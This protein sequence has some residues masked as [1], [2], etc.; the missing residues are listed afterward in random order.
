MYVF[1]LALFLV[2]PTFASESPTRKGVNPQFAGKVVVERT[3][4]GERTLGF[5]RKGRVDWI[6]EPN[7]K[8]FYYSYDTQDRCV[9]VR[10]R[11]HM[12]SLSYKPDGEAVVYKS[13][14]GSTMFAYDANSNRIATYHGNGLVTHYQYNDLNRVFYMETIDSGNNIIQSFEYGLDARGN[15][16]QVVEHDGRI[17][18]YQFDAFSR[19]AEEEVTLGNLQL[20]RWTYTYDAAHNRLSMTHNGV[21]T[22]YEYDEN[23]RMLRAGTVDFAYDD[24]GQTVFMNRDGARTHFFYDG[25][26]MPIRV[27]HPDGSDSHYEYD[28]FGILVASTSNIGG[29]RRFLVDSNRRFPEVIQE[30]AA[31]E[32]QLLAFYVHGRD[33]DPPLTMSRDGLTYTYLTDAHGNITAVTD[34]SGRVV[35]EYRY[36]AFGNPLR[37]TETVNNS[38][39]Y[40]G[41]MYEPQLGFYYFRARF[42]MPEFGRFLTRDEW[43]GRN[44]DPRTLNPYIFALNNPVMGVDPSGRNTLSE[45]LTALNIIATVQ[46][47]VF[48]AVNF[49]TG[50]YAVVAGKAA[51]DLALSVLGGPIGRVAGGSRKVMGKLGGL[52]KRQFPKPLRLGLGP[53]SGVL[54]Q[55][56]KAVGILPPPDAAAHHIVPGK[57]GVRARRLL[58]RYE[59]DINSPLN[60][61]YLPR[62]DSSVTLGSPHKGGHSRAYV[63]EIEARIRAAS[64]KG[65]TGILQELGKLKIELLTGQLRVH[66]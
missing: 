13:G 44:A 25:N 1:L 33:M 66:R 43:Q 54:R 16:I 15:R 24:K 46:E 6:V 5:D 40:A 31:P 42:Y 32:G 7:G 3:D 52:L 8:R 39:Q 61:V 35:N 21:E 28:A 37:K 18:H 34:P 51:E 48:Y 4:K 11:F 12:L 23:D 19:L 10:G 36:D 56:L 20:H 17:T 9:E 64:E 57:L 45:L 59:I 63:E 65:R 22:T 41:E 38:Y 49:A 50:N 30:M 29:E 60:G 58:E 2:L 47:G 53:S 62:R 27:Q 26:G 14:N 55:N